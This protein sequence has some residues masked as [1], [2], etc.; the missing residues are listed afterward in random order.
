MQPELLNQLK[1]EIHNKCVAYDYNDATDSTL[2]DFIISLI[3]VNKTSQEVNEEL[4]LLV[5]SD[6]DPNLT[7]WIF[8]RKS[9]LENMPAATDQSQPQQQVEQTT[10]KDEDMDMAPRIA[11]PD[12]E[13]RIFSKAIGSVIGHVNRNERSSQPRRSERSRTRSRSRSPVRRSSRSPVRHSSRSPARQSSRYEHE[14]QSSRYEDRRS[15]RYEED[16]NKSGSILSR[17]GNSNTNSRSDE[18]RPSVFDRLGGAKPIPITRNKDEPAKKERCKYWPNCKNGEECI[19]FHPTTVCP[20][21]PNCPKPAIE[22][23]FI[24]PEIAKSVMPQ[25]IKK[26][27]V[28]CKFFPYCSNPACPF[29]HPVVAQPYYMQ[30]KPSFTAPGQRLQIPCKNADACTRPD[31]HF[32]HPKDPNPQAD[33]VCKFDGACTRPNCFYK[34]TQI[35]NPNKVFINSDLTNRSFSVAEDEVVERITVGD[36]AD[37]ITN[38]NQSEPSA[39]NTESSTMNTDDDVVMDAD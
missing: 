12:R 14:R 24:H 2:S 4:L 3:Q 9:E 36:S 38:N 7:Q 10:E 25:Q 23:M 19:Y 15:G 37:L 39:M 28:P 34:H 17:L 21:F 26:L 32:L 35:N 27:A 1:I 30:P 20:D 5:G 6:Y 33:I 18:E 8:E 22:C 16:R 31:C 13:N 11:K 29:V